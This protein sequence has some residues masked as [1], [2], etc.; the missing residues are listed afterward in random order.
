MSTGKDVPKHFFPRPCSMANERH[1]FNS[2]SSIPAL[3]IAAQIFSLRESFL[4][5]GLP[6]PQ[7]VPQV[8]TNSH[9]LERGQS[10]EQTTGGAERA[11]PTSISH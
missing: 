7:K 10:Y 5:D 2:V 11:S 8:L 3:N 6:I 1:R 4:S 9:M